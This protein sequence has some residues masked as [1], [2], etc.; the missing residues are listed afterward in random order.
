MPD[1]VPVPA[2]VTRLSPADVAEVRQL[3]DAVEQEDGAPPLSEHVLLHLPHG[4]DDDVRHLLV[5]SPA[6][7]LT[8]Y[9]HLDV[10]D[11]VAGASG[12][13]A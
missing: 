2:V 11:P 3:V 9:A 13:L 6:G 12:E 7:H 1:P 5:R 10:T 4:G 8:G